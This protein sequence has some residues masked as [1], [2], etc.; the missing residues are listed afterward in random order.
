M[1]ELEEEEEQGL[2]EEEW[3]GWTAPQGQVVQEGVNHLQVGEVANRP[4][5]GDYGHITN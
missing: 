2:R 5:I 3:E 4:E 1:V